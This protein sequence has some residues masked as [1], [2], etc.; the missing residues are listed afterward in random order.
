MLQSL[1]NR[2]HAFTL[3]QPRQPEALHY[4]FYTAGYRLLHYNSPA[5]RRLY[6]TSFTQPNT[7]FYITIAPPAGGLTLQALHSR[8]QAFTLQQSRQSRASTLQVTLPTSH[9]QHKKKHQQ[10]TKHYNKELPLRSK[11]G[12]VSAMSSTT[13]YVKDSLSKLNSTQF[14]EVQILISLIAPSCLS[15]L[16]LDTGASF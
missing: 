5:R 9:L 15:S 7:G 4:K 6:I 8:I 16:Q 3:Q 14:S 13:S 1:H 11:L 2:I 12:Q 10:S